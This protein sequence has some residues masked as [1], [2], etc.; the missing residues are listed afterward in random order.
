MKKIRAHRGLRHW[1]G[2]RVR[3]QHTCSTGRRRN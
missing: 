2:V 1:W 3:G